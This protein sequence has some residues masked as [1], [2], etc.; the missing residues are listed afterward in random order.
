MRMERLGAK[1][2]VV[3]DIA[4][5]G[6]LQ[7][8]NLEFFRSMAQATT[9]KVIASGGVSSLEDLDRVRQ[10]NCANLEGIIVGRAL[11]EARFSLREALK[12][13]APV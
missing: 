7:G 2:F 1:R 4:R 10:L 8:P 5:D 11:Y 9:G 3:T 13:V 12:T 6:A